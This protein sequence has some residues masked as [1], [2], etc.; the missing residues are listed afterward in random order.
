MNFKPFLCLLALMCTSCGSS[1]EKP[2]S[3]SLE[4]LT[5]S[6][7]R[8]VWSR[9]VE[10]NGDDP[11]GFGDDFVLMGLDT[12]DPTGE[13]VILS[14]KSSY[15]KPLI[16]PDGQ[17][18][19]FNDILG[20]MV[21]AVKWD[22]SGLRRLA[23]GEHT[24]VWK[25][26][27]TGVTW[28][29]F[30]PEIRKN[31]TLD[32]FPLRRCRL[33]QPQVVEDVWSGSDVTPDGFQLSAD[34]THA[35]GLWPWGKAGMLDLATGKLTT[36]GKGCWTAMAP[37]DS[38]LMWIFDGA[39]KNLLLKPYGSMFTRKIRLNSAPGTEGYEVYHPRWSN[40]VRYLA[41]T[42]PYKLQGKYNAIT[43]G[44]GDIHVH[45]GR[46][47]EDFK[48][49]E[50]WA[51]VTSTELADYFPDVWI[52]GGEGVSATGLEVEDG[53]EVTVVTSWPGV[54]N[55]LVYLWENA[56]GKRTVEGRESVGQR[57]GKATLTR[58]FQADLSEGQMET[59]DA[60][61]V[62]AREAAASGEFSFEM[63]VLQTT[64]RRPAFAPIVMQE[65]EDAWANFMIAEKNGWLLLYFAT[66]NQ[67]VGTRKEIDMFRL[68]A[69]QPNHVVVTYKDGNLSWY[70]NG[71]PVGS[72]H[73][74]TG[75][76]S[77]WKPTRLL[78]GSMPDG[79][80][81]WSGA[82]EGVA[83]YNRALSAGEVTAHF[84]E[85]LKTLTA[86][87]SAPR[88]VVKAKLTEKTE[89]PNPKAIEPYRDGLVEYLYQVE[90]VLDGQCDAEEINVKHWGI[91]DA[92]VIPIEKEIGQVYT[93]YLQNVDDH[94]QL[95]GERVSSTVD[96]MVIDMYIDILRW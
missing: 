35:A 67:P 59:G 61:K 94:P 55:G 85:Q 19:V 51:K 58:F 10:R 53:G 88:V 37:D 77:T 22:G 84:N 62:L 25:D 69:L 30:M 90:K 56:K 70:Q 83:I 71:K 21:Y 50:A 23:T 11:L 52:E 27:A 65:D 42:G 2:V 7:T 66:D 34:G 3:A 24:E 31:D 93:L 73:D 54:I 95:E 75:G 45:V 40:H 18:I 82:I 79:S 39:H 41:M 43:A 12:Q 78:F 81:D 33:D 64:D 28:V 44:G 38:Y 36:R 60:G 49:I 13:R 32:G 16:S 57:V 63:V 74:V 72:M 20:K 26:P 29:Y 1:A 4:E 48:R 17:Q 46:F 14:N 92:Q 15:R 6:R 96:E 80:A 76:L 89:T 5:G 91:L 8:V 47:S 87:K 9:Q 68:N 86:R